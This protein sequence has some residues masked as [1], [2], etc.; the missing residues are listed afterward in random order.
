MLSNGV[1]VYVKVTDFKA[2]QILMK[3]TSLGG[4]SLFADNEA[5][6]ISQLNSVAGVGGVGNFSK[7][8][9]TKALAGKRASVSASIGGNTENISGNCSPKDFETMMQLTYL[10]FTAPRKDNEAFES[11]KNRLKA[12]LQNADA[13][14][15]R[16]FGDTMTYALY[17]NHPRAINLKEHMVEN[18][19]YDRIIEMY[20]DR[21]KDASDFTFYLVGN[22]DL[23]NMK[24]LIAKY[25][26]GLPAIKR[27]ETFRDTHMDI[28][29]GLYKN[30]FTKKQETPMATILFFFN[31]EC[32]YNLRNNLLLS[33]LDQALDM[34]YTEEIREKEGGTYGVSCRGGLSK[35][36]K[37]RLTLQIVFQTDPAKRNKLSEIVLEQLN[38]MAQEGPSAEHMQ[39][40]KEY[41]LK[42]YKDAQKEN[43]YWLNNLDEYFYTGVDYTKDYEALVSSI[44]AKDVQEFLAQLMEQK[45]EIRVIM[46]SPEEEEKK[47]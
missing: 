19:D 36:P 32:K 26:G 40:I 6:N 28:R 10:S 24:P 29:K 23:E 4:S 11:Y 13:N 12:Q 8:D 18:I 27:Q 31:G 20:K 46:T 30:E 22:V 1:K 43:S 41:M 45:N 37:E 7:V 15:M 35:Y 44:T 47:D 9:L 5:L 39:K 3:G 25:L 38:K 34:V 14:P 17:N 33:F 21:Y 16:A 2:D 42:K